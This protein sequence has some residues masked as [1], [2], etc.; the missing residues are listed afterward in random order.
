MSRNKKNQSIEDA[1]EQVD[2]NGEEKTPEPQGKDEDE[3]AGEEGSSQH[4]T[5]LMRVDS[6]DI[7]DLVRELI[8][9]ITENLYVN[10][11]RGLFESH[12]II[13]SFMICTSI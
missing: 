10:V 5:S 11:C 7:D 9:K 8:N 13:Y 12:K 6:G 3:E 4:S 1:A 2:D